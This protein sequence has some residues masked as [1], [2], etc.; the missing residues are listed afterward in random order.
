[1]SALSGTGFTTSESELILQT[2]ERRRILTVL[3]ITSSIGLASVV[4]TLV[5]GAFGIEET[6][7][8]LLMQIVAIILAIAFVRYVLFSS[9]VDEFICGIAHAWL[10]KRMAHAPYSVLYQ[11]DAE[12]FLA[13]HTVAAVPENKEDWPEDLLVVG[14]RTHSGAK[15]QA[16]DGTAFAD[17]AKIL[18]AGPRKSHDAFAILHDIRAL[19]RGH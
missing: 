11:L 3:I 8:G 18:L 5:I 16:W 9:I 13:E 2:P 4:A 7:S 19:Q 6:A 10:V 1:M 14:V 17:G 15:L 12:N